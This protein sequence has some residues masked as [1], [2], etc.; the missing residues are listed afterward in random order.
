MRRLMELI[1]SNWKTLVLA[2][3][4]IFSTYKLIQIQRNVRIVKWDVSSI[5]SD[6]NSIKR[7]IRY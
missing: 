4:M 1:K 2:I 3:F 5:E 7:S 6:V